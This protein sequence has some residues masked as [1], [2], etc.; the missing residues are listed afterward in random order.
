[1]ALVHSIDPEVVVYLPG[2]QEVQS[3]FLPSS[4]RV[5]GGQRSGVG[6]SVG[7]SVG[8][9][10]GTNVG[11]RVLVAMSMVPVSTSTEEP[12]SSVTAV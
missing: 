5:P 8:S 11:G 10:V 2:S 9:S 3:I 4:A 6:R 7:A 1:M 12:R